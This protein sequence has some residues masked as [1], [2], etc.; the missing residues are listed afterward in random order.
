VAVAAL[1]TAAGCFLLVKASGPIP[2]ELRFEAWRV[3]GGYPMSLDRPLTFVT[4]LGDTWVA[5]C[6]VVI[7]VVVAAEELGRRWALLV[8]LAPVAAA[9]T[10]L[11]SQ[12]LGPTSPEYGGA[13]GINLGLENNFPS[14]HSAYV[15]PVYGL[16]CWLALSG[17]H[18]SIAAAFALPVLLMAPALA[19]LGNHY[20]ADIV[21]GYGIGLAWLIALLL[22]GDRLAAARGDATNS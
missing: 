6:S 13:A 19:L 8:A 12:V 20:P 2:G 7:F 5:V 11:L 16:M 17:G 14:G 10:E 22:V 4:Y 9:F 18:R 3:G 15:V 21:A 1:A